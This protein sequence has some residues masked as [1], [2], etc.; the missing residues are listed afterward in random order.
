WSSRT[1]GA[2]AVRYKFYRKR[3]GL[4]GRFLLP[5]MA[6]RNHPPLEK[7]R[8]AVIEES[9]A[10]DEGA[11]CGQPTQEEILEWQAKVGALKRENALLLTQMARAVKCLN[12]VTAENQ[13]LMTEVA[14]LQPAA[15]PPPSQ[16]FRR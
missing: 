11:Q 4:R 3:Q 5:P 8:G 15:G 10:L 13:L 16:D 14:S 2:Y 12:A 7:L 9:M 6:G 1:A